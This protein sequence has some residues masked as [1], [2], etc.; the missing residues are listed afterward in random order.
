MTRFPAKTTCGAPP[1]S[2][3]PITCLHTF[4]ISG[5]LR[6]SFLQVQYCK[7]NVYDRTAMTISPQRP[8]DIWT[9]TSFFCPGG[10]AV[11]T[12]TPIKASLQRPPLY[13]INGH[14]KA[15]H[16]LPK[17]TSRQ[18]PVFQRLTKKS[19]MVMKFDPYGELMINRSNCFLIVFHL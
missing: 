6:N 5:K 18:P 3:P 15:R 7:K 10:H 11:H 17:K 8:P 4:L 12:L 13:N 1:S 2:I 14:Y 19:R 16:Q 9:T